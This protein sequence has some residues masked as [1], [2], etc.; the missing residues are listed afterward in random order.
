M[1]HPTLSAR[2]RRVHERVSLRAEVLLA[3]NGHT[4][5]MAV[6]NVSL[7]G[8]FLETSLSDH[9]EYKTGARCEVKLLIDENT[10]MHACEDGH[11]VH[12][13][14]RIVRRDPG[15]RGRPAGLGI[16]FERMDLETLGKLRALVNR[17]H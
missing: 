8:A 11:T 17:G 7:G 1:E 10:P 14:A 3:K 15:G 4:E 13:H 5:R 2:E 9:I 16:V 6:H 12:A